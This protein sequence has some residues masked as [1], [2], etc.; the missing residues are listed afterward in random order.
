MEKHSSWYSIL[1]IQTLIVSKESRLFNRLEHPSGSKLQVLI[2]GTFIT[3]VS[4]NLDE[5][6]AAKAAEISNFPTKKL[7]HFPSVTLTVIYHNTRTNENPY[8]RKRRSPSVFRDATHA[9]L[10]TVVIV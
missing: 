2:S 5:L 9:L 4:S 1:S 8:N 6:P 7:H 10:L 3:D